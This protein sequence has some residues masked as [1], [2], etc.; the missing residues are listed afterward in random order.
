[1][2][3]TKIPRHAEATFE[4][5]CAAH[6]A[7]CNKATEDERGWDYFVQFRRRK[8]TGLPL[9]MGPVA[10][11]CLV[12]IKSNKGPLKGATIKLS[13]A[14]EFALTD[15]PAFVVLFHY[16]SAGHPR[17]THILHVWQQEIERILKRV[18]ELDTKGE[19]DLQRHRILFAAS[20]MIRVV[21][22]DLI[23]FIEK[24]I[25]SHA[26]TYS[27]KKRLISRNV[28]FDETGIVG[29]I[30]FPAGL[31]ID[32]LVDM[33][34]GLRDR[35]DTA[36]FTARTKRFGLVARLPMI[37]AAGAISMRS[38]PRDCI[39]RVSSEPSGREISLPSQIFGPAIPNL[40]RHHLKFRVTAPFMELVCKAADSSASFSGQW[41]GQKPYSL[42]DISIVLDLIHIISSGKIHF[43]AL[44]EEQLL[45]GA[46]GSV[47]PFTIGGELEV[48]DVFVKLLTQHV[49]Q[50]DLP[51]KFRDVAGPRPARGGYS[52][53]QRPCDRR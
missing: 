38:H 51:N 50:H 5:L 8:I 7:T 44:V 29:N 25:H 23:P 1:M 33:Q 3:V 13:N 4:A 47:E 20:G 49:R 27:D 42:S 9:D 37:E 40:P 46:M 11:Q 15:L 19:N 52:Q 45:F 2:P 10:D 39:L 6:G 18:R 36:N 14:L 17:S 41:D 53:I 35:I 30:A 16:D 12:Q 32:E 48:A 34:I 43:R 24:T 22:G 31:K 21:D 26:P 28:G